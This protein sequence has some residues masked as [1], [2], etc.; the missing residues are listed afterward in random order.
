MTEKNSQ[1]NLTKIK[2][3]EDNNSFFNLKNKKETIHKV[4]IQDNA[5][6]VGKKQRNQ[7][8]RK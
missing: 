3:S 2:P 1:R 5:K 8:V 7:N 4:N 6:A